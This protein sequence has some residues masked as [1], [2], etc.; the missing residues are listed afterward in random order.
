MTE[1]A[2]I[3]L[4]RKAVEQ[5]SGRHI[6]TPKDFDF[7]SDCIFNECHQM[8]SVSTL[9]RIW[10][11]VQT[12]STP[13]SSSLTPLAQYIGYS[14]WEDYVSKQEAIHP[15]TVAKT[16]KN[17]YRRLAFILIP[18]TIV[19]LLLFYLYASFSNTNSTPVHQQQTAS[20]KRVLHKGED[21]FRTIEE[22]LQ[23]FGIEAGDIAYFRPV[24][25]LK[26]IYVWSPE[27]GNPVWHNEGDSL[28][29]LPTITE[30]WTPLRGIHTYHSP[31]YIKEVNAKLYYERMVKDELRI[32]FMRDITPGFYVF[33][34]IYRIDRQLSTEGKT[35][36]KRIVDSVDIGR[37]DDL[38]KL[39][40]KK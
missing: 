8:V 25:N 20:G 22:Y 23:L 37:L 36:W 40:S 26:Y 16:S 15:N 21:F 9:K 35:V 38:E 6:R 34:G 3:E 24:P 32:T 7:L 10:G 28:Q 1:S 31:E 5:K 14:D 13:R 33:L 19:F 17:I 2:V 12:D 11:Y 18:L 4:L 39:R 30:W 29:L 27:Y